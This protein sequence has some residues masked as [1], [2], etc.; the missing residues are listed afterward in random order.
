VGQL[1]SNTLG[2]TPGEGSI[3]R[4]RVEGLIGAGIELCSGDVLI[5]GEAGTKPEYGPYTAEFAP[6][7]AGTWT[8]SVPTL[9]I[10]T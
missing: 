10:S 9:G 2:Y 8:V 5:F 7:T 6:V 4:V 3:F 1:V